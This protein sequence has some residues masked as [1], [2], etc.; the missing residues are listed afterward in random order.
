MSSVSGKFDSG[1]V[2]Q[3][4][5]KI[6]DGQFEVKTGFL[7]GRRVTVSL[8]QGRNIELSFTDVYKMINKQSET[9]TDRT[10]LLKALGKIS[11]ADRVIKNPN[12]LTKLPNLF[13]NKGTSVEK[14]LKNTHTPQL[15]EAFQKIGDFAKKYPHLTHLCSALAE[16]LTQIETNVE[17][18]GPRS[19]GIVKNL[20]NLKTIQ[21]LRSLDSSGQMGNLFNNDSKAKLM[22]LCNELFEGTS[23]RENIDSPYFFVAVGSWPSLRVNE[24]DWMSST[25][26]QFR[27]F[28][29]TKQSYLDQ[30]SKK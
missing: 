5:N 24:K 13:F 27:D 19:M 22:T 26:Q 23:K 29:Y 7:I 11:V 16:D 4:V 3:I 28:Y 12:F 8:D 20:K 15:K 17:G 25:T 6:A 9:D 2:N 21:I 18:I 14:T 1:E 10:N 30:I